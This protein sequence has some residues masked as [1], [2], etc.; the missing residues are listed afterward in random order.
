M[1]RRL[2][3]L[4]WR[5]SRRTSNLPRRWRCCIGAGV[6]LLNALMPALATAAPLSV[7]SPQQQFQELYAAVEE[8]RLFSDSKA[9][10]DATPR[11]AP[12]AI[13]ADY[14][15]QP[16]DTRESLQAFVAAHFSM[17]ENPAAAAAALPPG[18]VPPIGA[19]IDEL[20]EQLTRTSEHVPDYGSLLALPQPYVVPG[21]RFRE[22]YY[23]DSYFTMLGLAQSG[24]RDLL[25]NMVGDFAA[26]ID[27]YGHVP[28]GTR[29]YYLSRSQPPFFFQMVALLA[30]LDPAAADARYLPQLKQEYAF[31]MHGGAH[32]RAG[33]ALERVVAMPDGSLLNRYWDDLDTPRDESYAEDTALARSSARPA[34]QLYRDLRAAAESGWDFSSRWLADAHSLAS[35][36]TTAI[37]PVD[38]NSLL[39]GLERA[40]VAGCQAQ[41][42]ARC[43]RE[44]AH[45][46]A[47]RRAAI[48]KFLWDEAQHTYL[49]YRWRER[50]RSPR[51]S[52]AMFYPLFVGAASQRQ[53][54]QVSEAAQALVAAGGL[55]TTLQSTGQQWDAPNGWAPLQWVAIA[56]LRGYGKAPLAR[57]LAC[58][59]LV[60]VKTLYARSGRLIEKYN[61]LQPGL[62]G[63][64]GE[65]PLQDGFGWTNGVTRQLLA[66]YP[67]EA[68]YSQLEQCP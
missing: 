28:N 38:L 21:G 24:R 5:V 41:H 16:P 34:P 19:H 17:P 68:K 63:G 60:S 54:G 23:W 3:P 20:W 10:A 35:I 14:R 11:S 51:L 33:E 56:G 58:R 61:V 15:A 25:E 8:A 45:H 36:E 47:L 7:Q 29:S 53:A 39:Y 27:R 66:L 22:L 48:D 30:P 50:V 55:A 4:V 9:F 62:S 67:E 12:E 40:I 1:Q 2:G 26:L 43:V 57:T 64:G 32:L 44:F 65:Y 49:D 46:A 42:E 52:A 18:S 37:V 6:L 13:L 31:W 59:W